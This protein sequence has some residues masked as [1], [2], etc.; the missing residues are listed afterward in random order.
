MRRS[1]GCLTIFLW[2]FLVA[3]VPAAFQTGYWYL[4]VFVALGLALAAIGTVANHRRP[5]HRR[6]VVRRV[7]QAPRRVVLYRSRCGTCGAPR[8]GE[9]ESCRHCG[10]SLVVLRG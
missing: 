1:S 8:R 9:D 5:A 7:V 10:T 2:V 6:P 4:G 3:L